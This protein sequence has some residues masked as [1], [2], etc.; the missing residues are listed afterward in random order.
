MGRKEENIKKAQALL[1]LK[2]RIRN[3]GTAA[4]IDHGKCLSAESRAWVN[5]RW[6]RAGDLW[7]QFADRRP[8]PNEYG[9]DVRDVRS[10][11]LWTQ[12]LDLSSGATR[13]AQITHMWRLRATEPLLEI[14]SRDGRRVKTTP[15]HPFVVASGDGLAYRE[16]KGLRR[17]DILAV[18]R[19]L[20]SR[21]DQ[22]EDWGSLREAIVR[23]LAADPRFRFELKPDAQDRLGVADL[24]DGIGL[25][26]LSRTLRIPLADLCAAIDFVSVRFQ[27]HR[28]RLSQKVRLPRREEME[29]FFWLVGLLYGDGDGQVRIHMTDEEMLERARQVMHQLTGRASISRHSRAPFLNPGSSTFIKLLQVAFGYPPKRKAWSIRLPDLLH[30]APLPVAAAFIQGYFDADGTVEKARSAVSATSVSE[31]F[32]DELQLLLLR[33]GVR[34]IFLRRQGKNTLYIS[35]RQNL[36]RMPQF[37]DPEKAALQKELES[38]SGTSYAVDL[39]PVDLKRLGR[40]GWKSRFY[41]S[42]GQR[43]SAV[44]LMSMAGLDLTSVKPLL[45]EDLAFVEV[46]AI[47]SAKAEWVYDFSVPGPQNFVAEGLFIHNTTLSDSLIAGAGMISE[48]LAGQQL[49]MDY[50]EQEQARGITI[51]AAIASMVHDFEGGQYLINLID[52]PGHV[53]FGGDVTRAMR[54]IDGVIILVDSVEGIMPQTETV[55]RQALKERV[56]P[57]L[58]INKVDRLVNELKISP[59]QM[60]QRFTKIITEVN[61][62]IRKWLPEDMGEKWMVHVEAGSVAFGSAYHKWALSVPFMKKSGITFKDVYK[63]CQDGT[64]KEL[65]KKAPLHSVVLN[66]V[67]RHLPNPLEAQKIRI[68]IIWKGDMESPVG[69]AMLSVDENGPVGFMVTKIIVDPQAG[70]VAAGRLFSGKVRR[71]QEL[72][73][74]GMPKPQRAQTVAMI[75]GPDRI[76]VDEIDAGNVV[77]V[78]GLKDAIAGSTVSDD[79][80]MQT[81]EK[82]VHYSD[83]VVTIAVEAKSTSD[84]PRLVEALRLIAKADPSIVVEINQETGEHLISGMGEL[85]L[86]ITIYRVQNDYKIPVTTSPPIVVYREG[87]RATGGPFEGKSPNKHNRFYMEVEPLEDK[88]VQAIRAGEIASG[89][90]IKDSKAL[91]KKLEEL[92]M[93]R[94]ESKN[95]VWIHDTNMLIDATKGIQYLHETMELIKEAYIEAMSKGPLAGEKAMGLKVRLVDAK[96]HEDSVHRGPAQVIPAARSSIYGAMVQGGRS[97]LEPIQ[98]V[99]INVPQDFMGAALGEIQSRRGVIEDINQEGEITVIHAKAPVAEMF[100]FASAIRSATQGR[101]LWS[102]E[103]SGFEPVPPNL[104]PEV[105]RAIR[106]R[107]GLPPEPYD[108]AYYAA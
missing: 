44:S 33:F 13:F 77:A 16:A 70:E 38:K 98:K 11:S 7:S 79:K 92:G 103:N 57:A 47:R 89:Q 54:A 63:H 5:G 82:I 45:S 75:V 36:A 100:G 68:P 3:I 35:G 67:I 20:L 87:V 1:H 73:V 62:R 104:Q 2:D 81:F 15:E 29:S 34:S 24:I 107:K 65:A 58:F 21:G 59:D 105:V 25:L 26:R 76:P 9:A 30:V 101:A 106:T 97:L 72:W 91:A 69:K 51:N 41:A 28:G 37:S 93:D 88:I 90:R 52:T 61:N 42:A 55:I 18:P 80:E 95:V 43:P 40:G 71:G 56:R 23:K 8:V 83:P 27:G 12:S 50:D 64:M 86:E 31:E 6:V 10:D 85:H 99:F 96:L 49:F 53:D 48:E 14:E 78:V 102:T 22:D 60:Q 32:L 19:R 46:K 4:H 39:L 66:M 84:L 108:E 74:I 17:G 94:N